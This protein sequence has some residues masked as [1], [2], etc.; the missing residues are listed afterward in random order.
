MEPVAFL[1]RSALGLLGTALGA[2]LLVAAAHGSELPAS[3]D[4]SGLTLHGPE[5]TLRD[6]CVTQDGR[7]WLVLPGGAR[8]ELVTSTTDQAIS[9]A[10]DGSFHPFEESQVRAALA[11]VRYPTDG[12][13]ADVFLL[14][15][16]RRDGLESAAGPQLIL[17]AP[18][19]RP[20]TPEHQHAEFI[21]ELGHVVQYA[22]QLRIR[23]GGRRAC[24]SLW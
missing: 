5:E 23:S 18:G 24:S 4:A 9:N 1:R 20:L 2:A 21:H 17:L 16:P 13:C 15:Y 7:L 11:A 6:Y 8:Y 3:G 22:R 14:P 12:L 19:V 10:G